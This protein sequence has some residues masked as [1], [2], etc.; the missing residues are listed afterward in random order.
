LSKKQLK[1]SINRLSPTSRPSPVTPSPE[2]VSGKPPVKVDA[3]EPDKKTNKFKAKQIE[4]VF[5]TLR[6][7]SKPIES[8]VPQCIINSHTT[9]KSIKYGILFHSGA[10]MSTIDFKCNQHGNRRWEILATEIV[11]EYM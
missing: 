9:I 8:I 10:G 11:S 4:N 6:P 5:I 7:S 3:I 2:R 1:N